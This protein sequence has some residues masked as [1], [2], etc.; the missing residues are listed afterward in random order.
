MLRTIVAL[1]LAIFALTGCSPELDDP[2]GDWST[3]SSSSLDLDATIKDDV[4]EIQLNNQG[5]SWLYWRGTFEAASGEFSSYGD[6]A[7]MDQSLFGSLDSRKDFV[8]EDDEIKFELGMMGATHNI[9]LHRS[10]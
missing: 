9:T 4:I 3:D 10:N 8:Y 5:T 1:M 2:T 7:A 6:T